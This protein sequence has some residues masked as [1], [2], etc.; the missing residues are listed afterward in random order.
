MLC[1]SENEISRKVYNNITLSQSYICLFH[2][3]FIYSLRNSLGQAYDK[4]HE[5]SCHGKTTK[6]VVALYIMQPH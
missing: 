3:G 1:S 4:V 2:A 5:I 6:M